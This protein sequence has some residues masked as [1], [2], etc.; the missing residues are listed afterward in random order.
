MYQ[1]IVKLFPICR[2]IT[3]NG[4]RETLRLI[5]KHIPLNII[6]VPS[7]TKV[8]DW[9]IP[10]EWN[11]TDA[12]IIDQTGHRIID[13]KNN[14]LHV[15]GYSIPVD[16]YIS[17]TELQEHLYSLENQPNAIPY[18]TSYYSKRWGFCLSHHQRTRLKE[19]RYHCV[20]NS[21]LKPGQLTY[22]EYIIPGK[23]DKEILISTYICHPSMANDQLSG[24][25]VVTYLAK[26]LAKEQRKY[27]YRI[28]FIPETIG[29]ITYLSRHIHKLKKNVIA[30]F[31]VMNVGDERTYSFVASRY[32]DSL[33]DKVIVK[34]LTSKQCHVVKYSYLDSASDERQF[35]SPG[36]DLPVVSFSRSREYPEY[37]TSLD[38]LS[39]VT[40]RGLSESL[41]ILIDCV[42]LLEMNNKYKVMCLCE[43]Q[44]GKRGLYP[45]L[46]TKK[47]RET[48]RNMMNFIRYADG[49]NDL[50]D[51]SNI[52]QTPVKELC[53]I[54]TRLMEAKLIEIYE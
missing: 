18:V 41:A 12:Y 23:T 5:K 16:C 54:I 4:V 30:G 39:L 15:V 47:S 48:V 40:P 37:H 38:N 14:N 13:F 35:C 50:I 19:G 11:I 25:T 7:G 44:L 34:V 10:D 2:S 53:P 33:A 21:E 3:G 45:T 27:T 32:G 31:N 1:L 43:P 49:K 52:T 9:T 29:S 26:W 20:I 46:S 24:P 6:E 17:L 22:G 42:K 51:I 8:F 36:V 28:I